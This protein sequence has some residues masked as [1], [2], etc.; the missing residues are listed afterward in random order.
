M[1]AQY[2]NIG[3]PGHAGF[4]Q[5]Y[6]GRTLYFV[7]ESAKAGTGGVSAGQ[8]QLQSTEQEFAKSV[9]STVFADIILAPI[10]ELPSHESCC[11]F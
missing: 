11:G 5:I 2:K 10:Q 1:C 6:D 7:A 8:E 9:S 4:L 3:W